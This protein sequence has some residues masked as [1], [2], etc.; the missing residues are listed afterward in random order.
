MDKYNFALFSEKYNLK[1]L[2]FSRA[3]SVFD[4]M[5]GYSKI[6]DISE[7]TEEDIMSV[8]KDN[9][10]V[11]ASYMYVSHFC[12]VIKCFYDWMSECDDE[13]YKIPPFVNIKHILLNIVDFKT[14][15]YKDIDDVLESIMTEKR[16]A[17]K[18][19]PSMI[20]DE[21]EVTTIFDMLACIVILY[22]YGFSFDQMPEVKRVDIKTDGIKFN[23]S[24]IEIPERYI[25][26]INRVSNAKCYT[27]FT[28][29]RYA[30]F[31]ESE[32]L[33][34]SHRT[35]K[36]AKTNISWMI[37]RYN[38]YVEKHG[39]RVINLV[40]LKTDKNFCEIKHGEDSGLSVQQASRAVMRNFF[41]KNSLTYYEEYVRPLY[42]IW[43]SFFYGETDN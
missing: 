23:G 29:T 32:Y 4:S 27:P 34:R 10:A 40:T 2:K 8:A 13:I 3:E 33:L 31:V 30:E 41:S 12:K 28:R 7:I 11:I 5:C 15:H 35:N 37:L 6:K 21:N 9:V 26:I 39:G 20:F 22:W 25:E 14:I 43:Y 19:K 36:F 17:K 1:V 24:I 18:M 38:Q 16:Q 42:D